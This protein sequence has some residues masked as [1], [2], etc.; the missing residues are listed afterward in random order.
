MQEPPYGHGF[1]RAQRPES[2]VGVSVGNADVVRSR[3][4]S[5]KA[6]ILTRRYMMID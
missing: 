1:S 4:V 2:F 5:D 3:V 6:A